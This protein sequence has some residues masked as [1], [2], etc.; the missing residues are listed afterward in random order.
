MEV[1]SE[2]T[3]SHT[4][5]VEQT[6]RRVLFEVRAARV[7]AVRWDASCVTEASCEGV[8]GAATAFNRRRAEEVKG[9]RKALA[10]MTTESTSASS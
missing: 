8:L 5:A 7:S 10:I 3:H 6:V 2:E 1:G 4:A 9:Q